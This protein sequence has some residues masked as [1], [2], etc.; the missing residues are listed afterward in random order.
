MGDQDSVKISELLR[1]ESKYTKDENGKSILEQRALLDSDLFIVEDGENTKSVSFKDLII[2]AIYDNDISNFT[3]YSSAKIKALIE[4]INEDI[5]ENIKMINGK[6]TN[7]QNNMVTSQIIDDLKSEIIKYLEKKLDITVAD[8]KFKSKRDKNVLITAADLD[9]SSDDVKIKEENLSSELIAKLTGKAQL[10]VSAS[11]PAG[12]WLGDDIANRTIIRNNLADSYQFVRN[13]KGTEEDGSIDMLIKDGFYFL[14]HNVEGLPKMDE[15]DEEPRYMR[16]D[17]ISEDYI[18]QT[19]YYTSNEDERPIYVRRGKL[20][21]LYQTNFKE[22]HEV[23]PSYRIGRD[24][25]KE[26]FSNNGAI[27]SGSIFDYRNEGFY[28]AEQT[29]KELPTEDDYLVTVEKH[30]D[31]Y[32][33]TAELIDIDICKVYHAKLYFIKGVATDT[34]WFIATDSDKSK[35]DKKTVV[36]LGDDAFYGSGSNNISTDSIAALLRSRYGM[37]IINDRAKEGATISKYSLDTLS[38]KCILSQINN[39]GS[40]FAK[41]DYAVILAGSHDWAQSISNLGLNDSNSTLNEDTFRGALAKSISDILSTNP[42]VKLLICTPFYRGRLNDGDKKDADNY[43]VNDK[44]LRDFVNVMIDVADYYHIPL[45][46]LYSTS[47]INKFTESTYLKDGLLLNNNGH[48]LIADK[49]YNAMEFY[50]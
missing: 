45:L 17:R 44:Y 27:S 1:K 43:M 36:L 14:A 31:V 35:F 10:T 26:E 24:M 34:Q 8:T 11:A 38:D 32:L 5:S 16:V 15:N 23:S 42:N 48:D 39:I 30:G 18:M 46:N 9:T 12:G 40:E 21:T 22:I 47:G 6:Y 50:F 28:Y 37:N 7:I 29:V 33:Y 3:L 41:V 13:V 4:A 19:V 2:S 25:L 49:I 20:D